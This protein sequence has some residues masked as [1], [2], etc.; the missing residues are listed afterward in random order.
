MP[1]WLALPTGGFLQ[2][3]SLCQYQ[4]CVELYEGRQGEA[5]LVL[6]SLPQLWAQVTPLVWEQ[7]PSFQIN[8]S[9]HSLTKNSLNSC[10]QV[11]PK[12]QHLQGIIP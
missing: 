6:V 10:A 9:E 5:E 8:L 3:R 1:L 11:C 12:E 7:T 2:V 4:L